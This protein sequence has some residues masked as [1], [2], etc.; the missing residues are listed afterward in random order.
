L[1][2]SYDTGFIDEHMADMDDDGAS[3]EERSV[4]RMLAAIAAYRRDREHAE[5][6][7]AAT[8]AGGE[9]PWKSFG[10]RSQMRG[11]LR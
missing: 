9:N 3:E 11:G 8:A 5:R 6:P 4:A 7:S 2:G 1:E 10:R